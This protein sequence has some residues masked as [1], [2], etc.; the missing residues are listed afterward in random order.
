[1]SVQAHATK[2][3]QLPDSNLLSYKPLPGSRKIYKSGIL[4]PDLRV[5][6]REIAISDT[7]GPNNV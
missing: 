7:V 2:R 1:M 4:H 6:F 3:E 5:P